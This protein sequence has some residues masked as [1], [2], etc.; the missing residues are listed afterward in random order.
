MS[1]FVTLMENVRRQLAIDRERYPDEK[2]RRAY[3][4]LHDALTWTKPKLLEMP[5]KSLAMFMMLVGYVKEESEPDMN[6]MVRF[7]EEW[8]FW[9]APMA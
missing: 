1:K 5:I 9:V 7:L 8:D 2:K 6:F 4:L 3:G